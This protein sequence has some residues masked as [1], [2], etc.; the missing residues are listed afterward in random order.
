MNLESELKFRLSSAADFLEA[1]WKDGNF[2]HSFE[3]DKHPNKKVNLT[4]NLQTISLLISLAEFLDRQRLRAIADEAMESVAAFETGETRFVVHDEKSLLIWNALAA[5]IHVKRNEFETATMFAASLLECVKD[6]VSS[7]YPPDFESP[8]G[9]YAE[10]MLALLILHGK[11]KQEHLADVAAYVGHLLL[12]QGIVPNHY[13]V[14]A[15]TLLHR[16]EQDDRYLRRARKQVEAFKQPVIKAM[17]SLFAAC[18]QQAFFAAYPHDE[19][20]G[21]DQKR[22]N[23]LHLEVLNQQISL[24]VD[25]DKDFSWT[26]AFYGA[27]V[28]RKTRPNIR[29]DYVTQNAFAL[30]QY[31]SH[32][33]GQKTPAI[34]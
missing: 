7:V 17:P 25:K 6:S 2:V 20:L 30:M 29:L 8:P 22:V 1:S 13:E 15:F 23:R 4:H 14:W 26:S 21:K 12:Q 28:L 9:W 10:T 24:Q 16:V 18:A 33:S 34:I 3:Q 19:W 11:T 5:I 32:L 31:L 27:F